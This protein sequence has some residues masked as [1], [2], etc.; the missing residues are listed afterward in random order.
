MNTFLQKC[1]GLG[2]VTLSIAFLLRSVSPAIAQKLT[3]P[4]TTTMPSKV[5]KYMI[6]CPEVTRMIAWDTETGKSAV[7]NF[8]SDRGWVKSPNQLPGNIIFE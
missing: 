5:G 7:Y 6:V 1:L 2:F 4:V 8:V 3:T